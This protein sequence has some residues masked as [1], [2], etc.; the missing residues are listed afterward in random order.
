MEYLMPHT[1]ESLSGYQMK[2]KEMVVVM[3]LRMDCQLKDT[4]RVYSMF[5]WMELQ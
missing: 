5:R 1:R 3:D 4:T 2:E